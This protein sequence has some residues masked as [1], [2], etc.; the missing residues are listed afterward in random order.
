MSCLKN[1]DQPR[2]ANDKKVGSQQFISEK[3]I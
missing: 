3:T 1:W 2:I